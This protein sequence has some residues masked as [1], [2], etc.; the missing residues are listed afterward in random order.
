MFPQ[1]RRRVP[2]FG[3][4]SGLP[5]RAVPAPSAESSALCLS[6][7]PPHSL[8][9]TLLMTVQAAGRIGPADTE[10]RREKR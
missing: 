9:R 2:D 7:S 6:S 4:R 5:G 10:S 1:M 8:A 3:T